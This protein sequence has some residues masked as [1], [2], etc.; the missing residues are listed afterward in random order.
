[1]LFCNCYLEFGK[2]NS[3]Q[4]QKMTAHY[5]ECLL[6]LH[7]AFLHSLLLYTK[8]LPVALP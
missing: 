6:K 3:G 7:K 2:L 5:F 1:M 8:L 4:K